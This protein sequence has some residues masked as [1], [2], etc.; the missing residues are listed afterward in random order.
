M[1]PYLCW[2]QLQRIGQS[3]HHHPWSSSYHQARLKEPQDALFWICLL[4]YFEELPT[5]STRPG[6]HLLN[7]FN[8]GLLR[9]KKQPNKPGIYRDICSPHSHPGTVGLVHEDLSP[10]FLMWTPRAIAWSLWPWHWLVL[11]TSLPILP[12]QSPV[13]MLWVGTTQF[14]SESKL[15][16]FSLIQGRVFLLCQFSFPKREKKGKKCR[17]GIFRAPPFRG[18]VCLAQ[19]ISVFTL[20]FY[21][22]WTLGTTCSAVANTPINLHSPV[23]VLV[24]SQKWG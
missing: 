22:S 3:N 21:T 9:S 1:S 18:S 11:R 7:R 5:L 4:W 17:R 14:S 20:Y 23:F 2:R 19:A 15:H 16:A 10:P 13:L 24:T 12:L 8:Q 6:T